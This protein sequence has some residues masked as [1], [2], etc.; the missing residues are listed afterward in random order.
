MSKTVYSVI[1]SYKKEIYKYSHVFLC[2]SLK[3]TVSSRQKP[4]YTVKMQIPEQIAFAVKLYFWQVFVFS[5]L[6]H[7]SVLEWLLQ[8]I[9]K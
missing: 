8:L 6:I 5:G 7:K 9:C 3:S 4:A 1:C 2:I